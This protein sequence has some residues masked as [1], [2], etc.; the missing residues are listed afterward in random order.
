MN[1]RAI[2]A[3]Q[4]PGSLLFGLA[5]LFSLLTAPAIQAMGLG[6]VSLRSV[7]GDPLEA[8]IQLIDDQQQLD[9]ALM[10][11]RHLSV[12]DAEKMGVELI[13]YFHRFQ[14]Q[15]IEENGRPVIRL[16]SKE[17]VTEPF[18]H[19][20]I[21][22]KWPT[23]AVYREYT[24]LVDVP[25]ETQIKPVATRSTEAA[26][27]NAPTRSSSATVRPA[28]QSVA[29][30]TSLGAGSY[31]VQS[32]DSLSRIA[33]RLTNRGDYSRQQ[34]MNWI[35]QNNPRAFINNDP[36]RIK[37]YV[38]IQLPSSQ[39]LADSQATTSLKSNV[40]KKPVARAPQPIIDDPVKPKAAERVK[41]K[42]VEARLSLQ[43]TAEA[44]QT[45]SL[46]ALEEQKLE[47][48]IRQTQELNDQLRREN[49]AIEA[50]IRRL[51]GSN[52]LQSLERLVEL[53]EQEIAELEAKLQGSSTQA[54][55]EDRGAESLVDSDAQLPTE[56]STQTSPLWLWLVLVLGLLG[57]GY[58][59]WHQKLRDKVA[60]T[61]DD[62]AQVRDE[63]AELAR[64]EAALEEQD[65]SMRFDPVVED[66]NFSSLFEDAGQPA[67][68]PY[69]G[70]YKPDPELSQK[71]QE[72]TKGYV[73]DNEG[74][75]VLHHDYDNLDDLIAEALSLC[76][77]GDYDQ[78]EQM[79]MTE[80]QTAGDN[81][82][83]KTAL[84]YVANLKKRL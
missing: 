81:L 22:L 71:I 82:R 33:K 75:S 57:S 41:K 25:A 9:P 43:T 12:K 76:S 18:I 60:K 58:F 70:R 11:V 47:D 37:A 53:R 66:V 39:Q 16:F 52:Y 35:H 6:D 29:A 79:L 64:L 51:E 46:R 5:S 44:S 26:V 15:T 31:Q 77:A 20:F 10:K 69:V 28:I 13:S 24:L 17:P 54:S 38:K 80:K 67:R 61:S 59:Y 23:G 4:K 48:R 19:L 32:G 49:Q 73:N 3:K 74:V 7:L 30:N 50:R 63:R 72:K 36:N 40:V 1:K 42:N 65:E 78:A 62:N 14:L 27:A 8:R 2:F 84:D 68:V 21:E 34:A 55:A 83:I 56:P 45:D